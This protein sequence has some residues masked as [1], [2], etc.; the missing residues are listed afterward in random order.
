MD[1]PNDPF[2]P[3][4]IPLTRSVYDPSTGTGANN[5]RQHVNATTTWID[6]SQV[7]GPDVDLAAQ[8]RTHHQGQLKT[9]AHN[10]L[11]DGPTPPGSPITPMLA[12]DER[13][14]EQLGLTSM[15]TVF[16]REHNRLAKR[17]AAQQ[18]QA[19]DEQVYQAAR[20]IVGAEIQRITYNEYLP[21]LMGE[22]APSAQD[23]HYDAEV[24]PTFYNS[25][26]GALFRFGHSQV[27]SSLRLIDDQ[28]KTVQTMG[29]QDMFFRPD[30]LREHPDRIDQIM[31]GLASG[32]AS[33]LDTKVVDGMRNFLF[34]PPGAGGLDLASLNIQRGRDHGLPDYNTLREAYG[35]SRVASFDDITS[36]VQT[37]QTLDE[38]YGDVNNIDPWVG[39]L[40]E[41]ARANSSLGDLLT[42]AIADQ[43]TRLRDGDRFFYAGDSLLDDDDVYAAIIDFDEVRLS[44]VIR[45]NTNADQ[46]PTNV[47][48]VNGYDPASVPT[49]SAFAAG[50]VLLGALALRRRR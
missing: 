23:Y 44:D 33:E 50:C 41:D 48:F 24:S 46:L 40:A 47:F 42:A 2:A 30:F 35:L 32:Y 20:H 22:D 45:W 38:L 4:P 18:P 39:A 11:P 25:F 31:R 6:A 9:S 21:A 1:D 3:G 16:M 19:S 14:N 7:Y 10:L 15:Q 43:F 13:V 8:L 34:G 37:Q 5:P 12:G 27:S 28:G 49:P 29:M 26:S 36:D 17:I